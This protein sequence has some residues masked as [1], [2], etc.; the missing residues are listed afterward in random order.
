[1]LAHGNSHCPTRA[2]VRAILRVLLHRVGAARGWLHTN[3]WWNAVSS[4]V[5]RIRVSFRT[6]GLVAHQRDAGD[7]HSLRR[8]ASHGLGNPANIVGLS[9]GWWRSSNWPNASVSPAR[10]RPTRSH[11]THSSV[12]LHQIVAPGYG[13]V[14][15]ELWEAERT[16]ED[17]K[18]EER[19]QQPHNINT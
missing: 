4:T 13:P 18:R 7:G 14:T 9:S 17:R 15:R 2:A 8:G 3:G 1:M 12:G 10:T 16:K 6:S 19:Q 11:H 5:I